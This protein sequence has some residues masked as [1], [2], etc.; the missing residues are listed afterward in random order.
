MLFVAS[1]RRVEDR[2]QDQILVFAATQVVRVVLVEDVNRARGDR[3]H[4]ALGVLDLA[5]AS[6][7]VA[8]FE[9]VAVLQFGLGAGAHDGV[10]DSEAHVVFRGEHALGGAATSLNSF[11]IFSGTNEHDSPSSYPFHGTR[12]LVGMILAIITAEVAF[13]LCLFGGMFLRYALKLPK[14]GIVLLA[15]T[16]LIDLALLV[17]T[18]WSLADTHRANFFHAFGAFYVVFSIVFGKD[19]VLALDKKWRGETEISGEGFSRSIRDNLIRAVI[20]SGITILI[21]VAMVFVTGIAGSF[22]LFYWIIA[23]AFLPACWWAIDKW[24]ERRKA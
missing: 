18:F 19:L 17:Y 14:A 22:W 5:G 21:L 11:D 4:V 15:A 23:M 7:A 10:R 16:P 8:G 20:A 12:K 24:V 9:V 1:Y 3:V 13:W 2:D 6:D